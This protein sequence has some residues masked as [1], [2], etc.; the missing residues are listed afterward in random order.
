MQERLY[1]ESTL[2]QRGKENLNIVQKL[3]SAYHEG[4]SQAIS[5]Y[6]TDDLEWQSNASK[7]MPI[8]GIFRGPQE[9]KV[10][11]DN[12]KK[13]FDVQ[14]EKHE[15]V[16]AQ[17]NL[18]VIFG[19]ERVRITTHGKMWESDFV[20]SFT[21]RD[22]KISKFYAFTDSIALLKAYRGED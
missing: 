2:N 6:V 19:R 16:V 4:N 1:D 13:L 17:G 14:W 12:L 20:V 18:V 21:F 22:G 9:V 11:F 15:Q 3:V 7:E 10:Y 5:T 8:G